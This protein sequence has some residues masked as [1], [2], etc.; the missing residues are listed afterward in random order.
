MRIHVILDIFLA[1]SCLFMLPYAIS[2]FLTSVAAIFYLMKTRLK[3]PSARPEKPSERRFLIAIP[4]HNED[5]GIAQTVRSCR[6]V[7][8]PASLFDVLVIA[9]NCTDDTA[10]RAHEAGARVLEHADAT[11]KSKGYAI[12]YLID[13]IKKSG[14]FDAVDAL[15]IIDADSTVDSNLL[16]QFASG[17]DRGSDWMQCYDC[18]GNADQSWRTRIMAYGFSLLNGVTLAG[19][20]ALGLSA[21]FRGNGMCMSTNGL[22]R[23]P[24]KARGLAEDL[25]YSWI[26]RLAGERIDFIENTRVCATM[27]SSGGTPLVDQRRRWEYGRIAVCRNMFGPVLRSRHLSWPQKAAAIAELTSQPTSH[28]ALLYMLLCV[29]AA[30]LIPDMILRKQYLVMAIVSISLA[31]ATVALTVHALSPF[32]VSLIPWR[33]ASSLLYFPYYILWRMHVLA[34]GRPES[35]IPTQRESK[36]DASKIS[37]GE[38]V[39]VPPFQRDSEEIAHPGGVLE[40]SPDSLSKRSHASL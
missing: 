28:I 39:A 12:E 23:I 19:W 21:S 38:L 17:L 5:A 30:A 20:K 26:V 27:L 4:A 10:A 33:F 36:S 25:E 32:I 14:E 8:Y 18:V 34:K 7:D 3:N 11:Q 2:M 15:V 29:A 6:A 24:W 40:P 35:W 13:A 31:V 37:S 1:A 9:D 22:R 16:E